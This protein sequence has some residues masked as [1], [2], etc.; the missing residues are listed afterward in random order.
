MPDETRYAS[1]HLVAPGGQVWSGGRAIAPL[2]EL[3]PGGAVVSLLPKA[4]PKPTDRVY[5]WIAANRSKVSRFVPARAKARADIVIAD[6]QAAA[7]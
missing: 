1:S 4:A 2:F 6:R 5:E 3:L 7:A